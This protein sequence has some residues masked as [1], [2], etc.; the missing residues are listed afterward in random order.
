MLAYELLLTIVLWASSIVYKDYSTALRNITPT[1][2]ANVTTTTNITY[3]DMTAAAYITAIRIVGG[4]VNNATD[5]DAS[6]V[7]PTMVI[8]ASI[9]TS[10]NPKASARSSFKTS[11]Q[12]SMRKA[13]RA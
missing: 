5:T 13:F 7:A 1:I 9:S 8:F 2:K 12:Q 10:G 6:T 11:A 3:S 4:I